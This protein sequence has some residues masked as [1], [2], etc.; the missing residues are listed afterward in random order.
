MRSGFSI[1][2]GVI[3]IAG[4][5]KEAIDTAR[6]GLHHTSLQAKVQPLSC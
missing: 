3:F 5:I 4:L 1:I 2:L 6:L